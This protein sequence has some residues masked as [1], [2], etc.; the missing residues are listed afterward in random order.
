[1]HISSAVFYKIHFSL[2][3]IIILHF[4]LSAPISSG[5]GRSRLP[6]PLS[7]FY[8]PSFSSEGNDSLQ[9]SDLFVTPFL[10]FISTSAARQRDALTMTPPPSCT[11]S[12]SISIVYHSHHYINLPER[13]NFTTDCIILLTKNSALIPHMPLVSIHVKYFERVIYCL[14]FFTPRSFC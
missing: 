8:I 11:I 3:E 1:M 2:S 14:H 5:C 4:V 6:H 9:Y 10:L 12:F 7:V 13:L